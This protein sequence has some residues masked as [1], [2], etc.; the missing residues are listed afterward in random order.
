MSKQD[1]KLDKFLSLVNAAETNKIPVRIGESKFE[2]ELKK[3]ISELVQAEGE[4]L[5]R[6]LPLILDKL[7]GLMVRP[8]MVAGQTGGLNFKNLWF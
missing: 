2:E 6:F 4:P 5:V 8:P 1:K 7:V 3:S